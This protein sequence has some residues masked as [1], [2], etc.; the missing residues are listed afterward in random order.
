MDAVPETRTVAT[1]G[2]TTRMKDREWAVAAV[3][4]FAGFVGNVFAE[5]LAFGEAG[6]IAAI[7]VLGVV[8]L[9]WAQEE[10]VAPVT[11]DLVLEPEDFAR[12]DD[13]LAAQGNDELRRALAYGVLTATQHDRVLE[14]LGP[15]QPYRTVRDALVPVSLRKR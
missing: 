11:P 9:W 7:L 15:A 13:A 6:R 1:N 5:L 10:L 14:L 12:I 3:G 8:A 2:P 4:A